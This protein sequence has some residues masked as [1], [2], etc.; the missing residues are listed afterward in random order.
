M[1]DTM[2]DNNGIAVKYTGCTIDSGVIPAGGKTFEIESNN[3]IM[4]VTKDDTCYGRV[5]VVNG[6][7]S[8][9]YLVNSGYGNISYTNGKL[10][11]YCNGN[12]KNY[13][14]Y[15]MYTS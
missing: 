9:L 11:L 10:N 3:I 5:A 1:V 13:S 7:A 8:V 12:L 2:I 4:I 14:Y 15:L 6:V